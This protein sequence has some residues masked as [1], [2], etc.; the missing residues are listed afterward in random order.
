MTAAVIYSLCA[1]TA[2]TCAC[3]LLLAYKRGGSRLLLWSGICFAGLTLNNIFLVLD[4]LVFPDIDFSGWRT[5]S[6]LIS[7]L[8]LLYGL[9]W[10][11]E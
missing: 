1:L 7:M 5:A 8:V 9:I 4:K 3:L 6:A 11:V 2:A 10:D